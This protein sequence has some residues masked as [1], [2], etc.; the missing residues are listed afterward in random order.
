[1]CIKFEYPITKE[2]PIH[3]LNK[4]SKTNINPIAIIVP[5]QIPSL[6]NYSFGILPQQ[7]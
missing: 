4:V 2:K 3:I 7:R 6:I 5:D 1:M